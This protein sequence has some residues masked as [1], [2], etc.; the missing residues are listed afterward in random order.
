[1][2][3]NLCWVLTREWLDLRPPRTLRAD[4]VVAPLTLL[5]EGEEVFWKSKRKMIKNQRARR[6]AGNGFCR[7]RQRQTALNNQHDPSFFFRRKLHFLPQ[8]KDCR[9]QQRKHRDC[10]NGKLTSSAQVRIISLLVKRQTPVRSYRVAISA[11]NSPIV[12][13]AICAHPPPSQQT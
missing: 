3:R 11:R 9:K 4:D 13:F 2:T 7:F 5:A 1:M 10:G 8:I 6:V 12:T